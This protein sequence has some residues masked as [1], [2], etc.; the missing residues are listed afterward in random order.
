MTETRALGLVRLSKTAD[1]AST[2]I[3]RQHEIIE[4]KAAELDAAIIGWA[5]DRATSAF[6]V[7][8][9]QRKQLRVWLNE[10][11]SEFDVIL[12]WRQDRI[13]RRPAD[14][15]ELIRWCLEHGKKLVSATEALGDV[16]EHANVLAGFLTAWQSEGESLN[17]SERV[18]NTKDHL[19]RNGRWP[20]GKPSYGY[21]AIRGDAGGWRLA[22]DDAES[23]SSANVLRD[24][25]RRVLAGETVNAIVGD[26]NRR[27][28]PSP[29]DYM[30]ILK[31]SPPETLTPWIARSVREILR[32]PA[33]LGQVMHNGIVMRKDGRP[34]TWA[35]PLITHGDW[36]ALQVAL[37]AAARTK[38]RTQTASFAL[39][40]A[41]CGLCAPVPVGPFSSDTTNLTPLYRWS[42][43]GPTGIMYSYY[44]CAKT[45]NRASKY[46]TCQAKPI[47]CE[48]LDAEINRIVLD[49]YGPIEITEKKMSGNGERE[50]EIAEVGSAIADLTRD[51]YV[52]HIAVDNFNAQI[53]ALQA[54][55]A[56]LTATPP[57]PVT[58]EERGTGVYVWERWV[59]MDAT[60][61]RLFLIKHG[62]VVLAHRGDDGELVTTSHGGEFYE[63]RNALAITDA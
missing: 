31:G 53:E 62:V 63:M 44:K 11:V 32:S 54:R 8:P 12:Y 10:R 43:P 49:R 23:D 52:D 17:A 42:K 21:I 14:F 35:E 19:R 9:M 50:R 34:L 6:K 48:T 51:Y 18:K 60:E 30:R 22:I 28:I 25:V 20:G 39:G 15:M 58:V 5:E 2:S 24:I 38:R 55:H 27:R 41:F 56:E 36:Q 57:T 13:V 45:Y 29:R 33:I 47:K 26:L 59:R 16:T 61:R 7:P 40:V 3:Q 46:A 1:S 37:D 4:A